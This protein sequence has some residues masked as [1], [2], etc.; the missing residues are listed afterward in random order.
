MIK[1]ELASKAAHR[2]VIEVD[3]SYALREEGEAYEREMGG[4]NEVLRFENTRSWN[5]KPAMLAT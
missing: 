3:G 4:E 2:E 1:S 5:D